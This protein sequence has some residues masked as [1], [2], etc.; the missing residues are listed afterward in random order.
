MTLLEERQQRV[1]PVDLLGSAK[2]LTQ[3]IQR[4]A[5]AGR[6][7]EDAGSLAGVIDGKGCAHFGVTLNPLA[8]DEQ[9]PCDRQDQNQ[10]R[11]EYSDDGIDVSKSEGGIIYVDRII[12]ETK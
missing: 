5:R 7:A 9:A 8:G 4:P 1:A 12:R 10:R 3:A 2:K 6:S 11:Y